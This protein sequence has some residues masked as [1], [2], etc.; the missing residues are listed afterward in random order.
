[1]TDPFFIASK[2]LGMVSRAETWLLLLML[3]ALLAVSRG[4][5]GLG[6]S[7]ILLTF[8]ITLGLTTVP[9]GDLLLIR[10]EQQYPANP[11][12][13][14]VD[15]IIVLGGGEDVAPYMRW[16]GVEVNEAGERLIVAVELARRFPDAKL[17]YTGGTAGLMQNQRPDAPSQMTYDAWVALG[18][19]PSRIVLERASRNTSENATMTRDLLKPT[20]GQVH[21]L[22]TS[23]WHMPRSM[24]T[25]TRAGWTGLVAWPVDFRSGA[26]AGAP[27][28]RLDENLSGLDT[29]LK[30]YLGIWAYRIAGK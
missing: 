26:L 9:V 6:K 25:F 27:T 29:A 5:V 30:E 24:E 17:V 4:R 2:T 1:M 16:G 3:L 10:L 20:P 23:A 13:T 8:V 12:V 19:D 15:D 28:W 22:V 7:L 18:V 14:H 11:P 21:L